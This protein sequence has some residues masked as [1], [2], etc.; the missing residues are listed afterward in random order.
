[1]KKLMMLVA[2]LA[3]VLAVAVPALAQPVNNGTAQEDESGNVELSFSVDQ[4][5]NNSDQC[6]TPQQFANTGSQQNGQ[7]VLQYVSA[8]GDINPEDGAF[9]FAP[10]STVPCTQA[11]Q[12]SAAASG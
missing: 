1:M 4:S 11:V 7:G 3:T 12:Q 9:T 10:E 8:S 2:M 6:V 5:G